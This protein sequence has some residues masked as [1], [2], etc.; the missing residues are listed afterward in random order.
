MRQEMDH[1]PVRPPALIEIINILGETAG[2]HNPEIRALRRPP[3][4]RRFA[5]I[6]YSRPDEFAGDE[7]PGIHLFVGFFRAQPPIRNGIVVGRTLEIRSGGQVFTGR[8]FVNAAASHGRTGLAGVH[9]P[10]RKLRM[11]PVVKVRMVVVPDGIQK[12]GRLCPKFVEVAAMGY[13]P[14]GIHLADPIV[15]QPRPTHTFLRGYIVNLVADAVH[16]DARVIAVTADHRLD[17]GLRPA[18]EEPVVIV[19]NLVGFFPGV[20]RFVDDQHSQPVA[21]IQ[22]DRVGRIVRGAHGV[23]AHGLHDFQLARDRPRVD[24]RAQRAQVVVQTD[25]LQLH[26]FSVQRKAFVRIHVERSDPEGRLIDI[27]L[28]PAGYD[29]RPKRVEVRRIDRPQPRIRNR[30]F[31]FEAGRIPHGDL[32]DFRGSD[33]G[34]FPGGG[35][36][37]HPHHCGL[38]RI[39]LVSHA[40]ID[41][42][43][44]GFQP[45]LRRG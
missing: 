41:A 11:I 8:G 30:Y 2:V 26:P 13:R 9:F 33:C 45:D 44:G 22:E 43:H 42:D 7:L 24:R 39:G 27:R 18:V 38:S 4:G 32:P 34:A 6:I 40:E 20:E 14:C 25:P 19:G 1:R 17:V 15:Q 10:V 31:H 28:S 23:A 12:R 21:Q 37:F 29:L 36:Y 16:D 5:E 3:V 35:G